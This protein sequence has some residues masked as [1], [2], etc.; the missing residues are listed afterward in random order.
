LFTQK[1]ASVLR[2]DIKGYFISHPHLDHLAGLVVNSPDDSSKAIYALPFCID[3]LKNNYFTW[4]SWANFGNEGDKPALGKYH[5]VTL[6]EG[7]EIAAENTSLFVTPYLLS[8]STPGQS[9]AFLVRSE[10]A[11]L[12]YLGDTGADEVEKAN[13]LKTLWQNISPLVKAKKLKAIF[14]EV[15]FPNQQAEKLLFGHL[16]PKLLMQEMHILSGLAGSDAMKG[17]P[18]VITHIKPNGNNENMIK[19]QVT[20]SNDLGLK[21][22]FP[23]QAKKLE[24]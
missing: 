1:V 5:Y 23:Q 3:V 22:I 10:D 16:T 24:F 6:T 12:L 17:L 14:I 13:N 20:A 8:H 9:T 19:E 4:K 18:V 11:Y 15:S 2:T 7:K 21:I